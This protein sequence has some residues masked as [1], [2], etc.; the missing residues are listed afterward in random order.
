MGRSRVAGQDPHRHAVR[1][2]GSGKFTRK[3]PADGD[4]SSTPAA[5]GS[6]TDPTTPPPKKRAAAPPSPPDPDRA[7]SG[8]GSAGST[9]TAGGHSIGRRLWSE[10]LGALRRG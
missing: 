10:G 7:G 8:T 6:T 2:S 5:G 4:P 1:E 9:G 3:P